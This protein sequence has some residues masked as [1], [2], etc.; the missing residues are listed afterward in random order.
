[1][2]EIKVRPAHHQMIDLESDPGLQLAMVNDKRVCL[3]L[4]TVAKEVI[5]LEIPDPLQC[6][7]LL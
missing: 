6:V 3:L 1:M 4:Q 2:K 7:H 5:L